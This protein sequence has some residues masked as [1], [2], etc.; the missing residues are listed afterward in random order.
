MKQK[1]EL[2]ELDPKHWR[3]AYIFPDMYWVSDK[4]EA[5]SVKTKRILRYRIG[6]QGY[7]YYVFCVAGERHTVKAHK[8]VAMAF[9]ENPYGKPSIDHINGNKLD[10]RVSNLRWATVKENN[11]NPNTIPNYRNGI[12]VLNKPVAVY[13]DRDL[14]GIYESR[15]SAAKAIGVAPQTVSQCLSKL[16]KT[17]QARGYTF[18]EM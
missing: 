3:P 18:L 17:T 8:L 12:R 1:I 14:I 9:I 7:Q 10:N 5:Y 4:G 11:N 2:S 6:R 15:K 16:K 13:K